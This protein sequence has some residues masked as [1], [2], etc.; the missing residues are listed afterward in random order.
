MLAPNWEE[1]NL[2]GKLRHDDKLVHLD[3]P[4][5]RAEVARLRTLDGASAEFPLRLIGLREL[6][7][8]NSWMHN[9]E[10]LM[11]GDRSHRAR[12]HPDDAA[13]C[14]VED[15]ARCRITS[16]HGQVEIE[17][18]L[19]DE[20]KRGTVAVPHGWGHSGG[21]ETANAAGGSNVDE[22]ASSDPA[23]LERLAGMAHLNG[24]PIRIGPVVP[25][26]ADDREQVAAAG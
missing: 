12:L 17:A 6:R 23:D 16:P 15:G 26:P 11:K 7:S 24:I 20:V 8:H 19:T 1:G 10:K 4:E 13:D 14:G 21:W 3:P 2:P 25:E 9:S 18:A 5:I 22:L